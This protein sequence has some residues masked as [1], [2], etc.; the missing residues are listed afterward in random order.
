MTQAIQ[1]KIQSLLQ[2]NAS[3]ADGNVTLGDFRVLD[4]G[5]PPYYVIMPGPVKMERG[6]IKGAVNFEWTYYVEVF[7]KFWDNDYEPLMTARQLAIDQLLAYGLLGRLTDVK[8]FV[9]TAADAVT[10]IYPKGGNRDAL[11]QFV[12]QRITTVTSTIMT[13]SGTGD[14]T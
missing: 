11:P 3:I 10:Y 1:E 9:V 4:S 13:Y 14:Y 12:Q 7:A 2:A 5:S 8:S 6:S